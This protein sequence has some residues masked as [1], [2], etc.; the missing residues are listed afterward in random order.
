MIGQ[1]FKS[2][3]IQL[4]P[5]ISLDLESI[6]SIPFFLKY[7]QADQLNCIF[8]NIFKKRLY[9][10]FVYI[11]GAV[12]CSCPWTIWTSFKFKVW[13]D[14]CASVKEAQIFHRNKYDFWK[15]LPLIISVGKFYKKLYLVGIWHLQQSNHKL[16]LRRYL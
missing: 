9:F 12:K 7:L 4:V 16:I 11:V 3:G 2:N 10:Y 6:T 14:S 15:H 13:W 5:H 8:S 1:W